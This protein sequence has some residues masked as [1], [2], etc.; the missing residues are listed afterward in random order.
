[1]LV[2]GSLKKGFWSDGRLTFFSVAQLGRNVE[3]DLL[4]FANAD[5][6]I[7]P[8]LDDETVAQF[9]RDGFFAKGTVKLRVIRLQL[10]SVVH[11]NYSQTVQDNY[12]ILYH[13]SIYKCT[14]CIKNLS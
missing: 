3:C 6:T 7:F 11:G 4:S 2:K 12:L 13:S 10:A 14:L 5:Q 1:M 8:A 9:E